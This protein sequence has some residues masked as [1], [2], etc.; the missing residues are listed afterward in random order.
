VEL[1]DRFLLYEGAYYSVY[2]HAESATTSE[3]HEYF[4]ECD[5]VTKASLLYLAKRMGDVGKIYDKSKFNLEDGKDKI[6]A[7]KPKKER[8]F[9]FFFV[10]KTIVITSAYKKKRQ[11]LDRNE[12]KK[13]IEIRKKYIDQH[14]GIK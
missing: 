1:H 6:Y 4:E 13:A 11:K 9:C 12:L 7:F 5:A 3:V 8:F 10:G 2:F 14:G